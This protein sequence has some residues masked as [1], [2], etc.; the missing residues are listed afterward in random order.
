[1]RKMNIKLLREFIDYDS[2]TGVM[3]WRK[4]ARKH[5]KSERDWRAWN[6]RYAGKECGC[7]KNG[8]R[9]IAI[10]DIQYRG[11]RLA[12]AHY[13]GRWPKY[14]IDHEDQNPLNNCITNLR[15]TNENNKNRG[16]DSRNKSGYTGVSWDSG[17]KKWMAYVGKQ[18][19]GRF[20]DVELA[21]FVCELTRD[22]LGYHP[23][24]GK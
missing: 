23:N 18:Y 13:H 24:H 8:Y 15:D 6:T 4:R 9:I 1:M 19:L 21:G 17:A 20:E 12:F 10:N 22:K 2:K 11:H 3:I 5:F 14:E 16:K 7:I